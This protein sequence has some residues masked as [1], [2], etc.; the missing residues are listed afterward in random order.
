MRAGLAPDG[1][2]DVD[3]GIEVLREE[4][5]VIFQAVGVGVVAHD[6][7]DLKLLGG[8]FEFVGVGAGDDD[9]MAGV[10]ELCRHRPADLVNRS[11]YQYVHGGT[12][13]TFLQALP[14]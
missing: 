10:A 14:I 2:R 11:G 3:D 6:G 8:D 1:I 7:V 13:L 9:P 5:D 4:L 12:F